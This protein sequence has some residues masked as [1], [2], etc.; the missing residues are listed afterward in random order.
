MLLKNLEI[1]KTD[2][3]SR[4]EVALYIGDQR[5]GFAADFTAG[6]KGVWTIDGII[7]GRH[8]TEDKDYILAIEVTEEGRGLLRQRT[9]TATFTK[10]MGKLMGFDSKQYNARFF[11]GFVEERNGGVYDAAGNLLYDRPRHTQAGVLLD[12][13]KDTSK[14][15]VRIINSFGEIDKPRARSR[16]RFGR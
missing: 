2:E 9:N 7:V 11:R 12:Y 15:A 1:K 16:G 4:D 6:E 3:C 8:K 10:R 5:I 14:S 13:P